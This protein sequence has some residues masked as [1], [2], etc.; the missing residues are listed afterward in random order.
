MA[1]NV[2]LLNIKF[3]FTARNTPQQNSLVEK[4]FDTIYGQGRAILHGALRPLEVK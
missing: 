2:I 3:E 4:G 1:M